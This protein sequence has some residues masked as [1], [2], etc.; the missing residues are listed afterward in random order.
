MVYSGAD[1]D[2]VVESSVDSR[3]CG[4][5][6]GLVE[7]DVRWVE[8]IATESFFRCDIPACGI[9]RNAEQLC[10]MR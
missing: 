8:V 5:G 9:R 3:S 1:G 6:P 2:A 4:E 7:D 10:N